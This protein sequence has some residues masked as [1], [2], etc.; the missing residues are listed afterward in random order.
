MQ[1]IRQRRFP[2]SPENFVW[3]YLYKT[4]A[5][6][7]GMPLFL[8]GFALAQ[9]RSLFPHLL[10]YFDR[11]LPLIPANLSAFLSPFWPLLSVDLLPVFRARSQLQIAVIWPKAGQNLQSIGHFLATGLQSVCR[12]ARRARLRPATKRYLL[13]SQNA[14]TKMM[15]RRAKDNSQPDKPIVSMSPPQ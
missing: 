6:K 4:G 3:V 8:A 5:L 13:S 11:L 15:I 7:G 10:A 12:G 14:K 9:F 2:K 1:H